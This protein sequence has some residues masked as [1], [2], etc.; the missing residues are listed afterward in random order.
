M[1]ML[2]SYKSLLEL[3]QKMEKLAKE[4]HWDGLVQTEIERSHLLASL[5][6]AQLARLPL[7]EQQAIAAIIRQIQSCDK[8]IREY[9][10]P[11]QENVGTLLARL[12]PKP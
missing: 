4:L 7:T 11:W 1:P 9:V 6:S 8:T 10:Q 3:S 2:S 5:P 12:A